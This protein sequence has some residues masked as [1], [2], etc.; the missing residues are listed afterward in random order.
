MKKFFYLLLA[1][2]FTIAFSNNAVA[3]EI[4]KGEERVPL[5]E[6]DVR[7]ANAPKQVKEKPVKETRKMEVEKTQERKNKKV[8]R[9]KETPKDK[10]E[11]RKPRVK[12]QAPTDQKLGTID[13]SK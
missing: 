4:K 8:D 6:L 7:K 5:N 13:Q 11:Q 12:I 10:S 1:G 2:V 3:Q 9:S